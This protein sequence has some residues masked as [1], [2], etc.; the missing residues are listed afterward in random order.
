VQNLNHDLDSLGSYNVQKFP[1]YSPHFIIQAIDRLAK[2]YG[3]NIEDKREFKI[4]REMFDA[5]VALLGAYEFSSDN[6]Y[7]MQPNFQS[8]SPDVMAAKQTEQIGAPIL[9]E[10][11]QMEI[12]TM[13]EYSKT[14]DV[15]EF[16]KSTKLSHKK[17]YDEKTLIV[18]IINKKIQIDRRKIV[19]DLK[20]ISPKP[21]IY[22]LGK[23]PGGNDQWAIF[24][25]WPL[26]IKPVIYSLSGT[27]RKFILPG[28]ITLHLGLRYKI[29]YTESKK[30][31]ISIY[32]LFKINKD[33]VEKYRRA[34]TLTK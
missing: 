31:D 4:A 6:K 22:I 32:E 7:F 34:L 14:D 19:N 30:V 24:S 11:N 10:I 26:S 28:S 16:L 33:S 12:V 3:S 23:I 18:C 8:D 9:L 5:A 13:N 15:V 2:I 25:P 21:T 1:W 17:A 20:K 29:G 27:L